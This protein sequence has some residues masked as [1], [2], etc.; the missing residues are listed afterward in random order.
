MQIDINKE[1]DMTKTESVNLQKDLLKQLKE[2]KETDLDANKYSHYTLRRDKV[3]VRVFKFVP[4][5]KAVMSKSVILTVSPLD[6]VFKPSAVAQHEKLYPIVKIIDVGAEA[7][8]WIKKGELYTVP[9][10]DVVGDTWNPDFQWMMQN[11]G[12]KNNDGDKPG[13]VTIPDDMEQRIPKL[14]VNWERYKFSMPDR[15]G[16]EL[17]E[18]KLVYLIPSLKIEADYAIK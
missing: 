14:D 17:E 6:G 13:M 15:I 5:S 1:E 8:D 18:D 2:F 4:T 3:L 12:K 11:F 10:N 9:F 16:D 7:P